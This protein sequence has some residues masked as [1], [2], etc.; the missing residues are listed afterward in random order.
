MQKSRSRPD[1]S[2]LGQ[3]YPPAGPLSTLGPW[4]RISVPRAPNFL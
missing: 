3:V 2:G 4:T 1:R